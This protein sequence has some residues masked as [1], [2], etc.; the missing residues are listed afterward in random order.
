MKKILV[1]V[2]CSLFAL[3]LTGCGTKTSDVDPIAQYGCDVLN[4]YNWGE[5]VGENVIGNFERQYNVKVNYSLFDSNEVMYTKLLGG[6]EYD[7]LVPSDYMIERL[8]EEN[9]LQP[10]DWNLI[11]NK[12]NLYDGI[13]GAAFDPENTYSAPYFWGSVGIVYN[14]NNVDP[15]DVEKEGFNV[16]K[17]SKYANRVYMYDSERDSFMIALKAL[18]YSMNTENM[19]EINEAYNWLLELDKNVNPAYVTDEVID[20]MVNGEKDLAVVYSGDAAYILSENEDM[21]YYMPETGTNIW[22]DAMVI[23]ANSKCPALAHEFIN[24]VLTDDAS[25]D[26]SSTVGYASSNKNV[27]E[28]MTA[29][30]GEFDGNPAYLPRTDGP[31]DEFFKHNEAMKKVLSDLW[32]KVKNQ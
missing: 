25:Y 13:M 12:E 3:S 24:F 11:T 17:N 19:D 27:L 23:P 28:E 30:G 8:V 9:L 14:K 1:T 21:D 15:S 6:N 31:N 32:I 20:S 4:V 16:L 26:N 10:I 29:E 5:Y 18:G 7:I 22:V 2:L